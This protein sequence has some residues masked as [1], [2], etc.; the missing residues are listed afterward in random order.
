M[1]IPK[2]L[3]HAASIVARN[4]M[5]RVRVLGRGVC[6]KS[7]RHSPP[8][9]LLGSSTKCLLHVWRGSQG[10]RRV[11]VFKVMSHETILV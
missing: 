7:K 3:T 5:D 2:I 11:I 8:D 10:E 6:S 1:V 4:K 9:S